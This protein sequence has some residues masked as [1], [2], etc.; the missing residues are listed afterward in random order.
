MTNTAAT[1]GDGVK[2]GM[3]KYELLEIIGN[4]FENIEFT[5]KTIFVFK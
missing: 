2:I 1:I 5:S 3:K 4:C